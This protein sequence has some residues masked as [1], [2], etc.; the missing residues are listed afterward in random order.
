MRIVHVLLVQYGI[1]KN[2]EN[3]K[4]LVLSGLGFINSIP[5]IL[6]G[7]LKNN[8]LIAALTLTYPTNHF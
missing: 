1:P 3:S 8:E 2:L 7:E 6:K 4:G 5:I